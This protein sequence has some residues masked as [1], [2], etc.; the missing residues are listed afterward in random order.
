MK[1]QN[2]MM[3][4]V[5]Q[6]LRE[7]EKEFDVEVLWA[8]ESGSRAW[9]FESPDS[10][11]DV[12]F[13]YKHKPDFYLTLDKGRDVI[14][15]PIDET[16]DVSGWD[17]DKTLKLLFKSNPTLFEWL[18]S[19]IVYHQTDFIERIRK[20]AQTYFSEKKM[21]YHYLNTAKGN[22]QKYLLGE[23]VKPKKY[24]YALRP[25]LA[26]RWIEKYH[27]IPPILFDD[28]VQD[29]LPEEMKPHVAALLDLKINHPEETLISP[30]LPIQDYLEES[31]REIEAYIQTVKDEKQDIS[32]L[33]HFFLNE[34]GITGQ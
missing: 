24:F 2:E 20:Y 14:E 4:L 8:I 27:T 19:P 5:P 11:F 32:A 26:C 31:I 33:N 25:I 29:L 15:L 7:I 3:T 6:K 18:Q 13:I 34:L 10:D 16:W 17:L 21:L 30:L 12:R 28:L 1:T 23:Q 9:G 22:M